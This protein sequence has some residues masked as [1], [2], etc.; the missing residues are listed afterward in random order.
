MAEREH[1]H[2]ID[3][4]HRG[5]I[6]CAA[7]SFGLTVARVMVAHRIHC[8]VVNAA[9][10]VPRLVTDVEIA[11]ALYDEQLEVRTA[12]ELS[13]P[14]PLLRP[15]DTLAFALARMH[16]SRLTHAIVVGQPLRL[17]GVVSVLDIIEWTLL[18]TVAAAHAGLP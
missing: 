18:R 7:G 3:A 1:A 6:T 16:E 10:D 11:D 9:G 4:M 17:L 5:V 2:V 14:A 12:L 13:R 8:V 15:D